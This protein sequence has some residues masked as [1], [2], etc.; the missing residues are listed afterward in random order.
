MLTEKSKM[1]AVLTE[2]LNLNEASEIT[3]IST[4]S[5]SWGREGLKNPTSITTFQRE[6]VKD[7]LNEEK[8]RF[9]EFLYSYAPV[10]SGSLSDRRL[11][12]NTYSEFYNIYVR[13][14]QEIGSKTRSITTII[15]WTKEFKVNRGIF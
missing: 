1:A 3:S 9:K 4:S 12:Y 5:I 7:E 2:G 8:I 13:K 11:P 10:T 6:E 14:I 15:N